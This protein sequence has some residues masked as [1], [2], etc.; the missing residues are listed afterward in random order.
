MHT[1]KI[2]KLE[3]V[4]ICKEFPGVIANNHV[5]LA[6]ESGRILALLGENGAGKTTLMN[7]LYGM[8][9]PDS[10]DIRI[11]GEC[12]FIRNPLDAIKLGIGMV[13]QHYMLVARHTVAE[14][15][16]L[17]LRDVPFFSP[18]KSIEKRLHEFSE[19][20]GLKVNP[21]ARVWQLS[22]GEQQRVEIVK[23]LFRGAEVLI[24]DEPTSVL[25]P[26]EAKE[27]FAILR[28]M[29]EAG[30][31]VI[32]ITHK[33][34]EVMAISTDVMALRQGQVVGNVKTSQTG[35]AELARMMVGREISFT[36]NKKELQPGTLILDV[37][38]LVVRNDRDM[39]AVKGVSFTLYKN[40]IFG[41]AGVS[42]NGQKELVE[43]VTGLRKIEAG[44][45]LIEDKDIANLSPKMISRSGV[46]HVPEE[47][48]RFGIA[49]SLMVYE[50]TVLKDYDRVP[51][52]K[53]YILNFFHIKNYAKKLMETFTVSASSINV[54]IKHLSGGNI[55]KLI[56]GREIS[57]KASLIVASH[58]TYGLDIGATECIRELLL[59]KR[60]EGAAILLVS[61]DLDE[62]CAL[63][64]RIA[65][66]FEGEFMGIIPAKEVN[67]EEVGLMMAGVKQ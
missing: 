4:D 56:L 13:H 50:N 25:T 46:S 10:G 39:R 18:V 24:L 5:N 41:I 43:A 28:K 60:E 14:N 58:P 23:A 44:N 62:L 3:M 59:K 45:V 11:N 19:M 53:S 15:V 63:S 54:P 47:R 16:A 38:G 27:L 9:R 2:Q 34:E 6:V 66:M 20:Y 55:Q 65:V 67:R 31:S 35:K 37:N 52:S 61:E 30:H 8:Y 7:I 33:L 12:V 26:Q 42:G 36:Y 49:P 64:D 17:G 51:F 48:M 22:A 40:E 1:R 32:F 57:G 29:T 21:G